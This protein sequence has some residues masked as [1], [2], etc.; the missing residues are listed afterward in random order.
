MKN[1]LWAKSETIRAR[2][3]STKE[4][5]TRSLNKGLEKV[6]H[7]AAM[8]KEIPSGV[9]Y[10][11]EQEIQLANICIEKVM[12]FATMLKEIT[13]GVKYEDEQ[14]TQLAPIHSFADKKS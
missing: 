12:H 5:E 13:S 2:C 1:L 9:K 14:E 6:M 3:K 4:A 11:E 10:E 8:L 7:F